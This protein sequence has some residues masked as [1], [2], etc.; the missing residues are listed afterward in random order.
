MVLCAKKWRIA[1]AATALRSLVAITG[2]FNYSRL[3]NTWKKVVEQI[4]ILNWEAIPQCIRGLY[5]SS[6]DAYCPCAFIQE[7]GC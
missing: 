3:V 2:L 6:P 7:L 4:V 1:L 5:L